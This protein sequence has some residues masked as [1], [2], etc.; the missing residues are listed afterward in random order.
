MINKM[1]RCVHLQS[2][3][4]LLG[5]K[6]F[7]GQVY[8]MPVPSLSYRVLNSWSYFWS[9]SSR[10]ADRH[11]DKCVCKQLRPIPAAEAAGEGGASN[12]ERK[13][14]QLDSSHPFGDFP[15]P[16]MVSL[17]PDAI[18]CLHQGFHILRIWGRNKITSL[19]N[20]SRLYFFWQTT[21]C[22][23]YSTV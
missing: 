8:K 12:A 21:Q 4:S 16:S 7:W 15:L 23:T 1:K 5:G 14:K 6:C 22:D 11:Q 9:S 17:F 10:Y 13:A 3:L 18:G 20:M 19:L 2:M